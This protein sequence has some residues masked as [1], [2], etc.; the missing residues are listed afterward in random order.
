MAG[1]PYEF[2]DP[3]DQSVNNPHRLVEREAVLALFNQANPENTYTN[4][5]ET[6][7][8]WFEAEAKKYKWTSVTFVDQAAV[9]VATVTLG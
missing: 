5:S 6:V 2:P 8:S 1:R 4:V 3:K 7:R 9:L